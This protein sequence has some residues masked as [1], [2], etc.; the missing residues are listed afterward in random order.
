MIGIHLCKL[1]FQRSDHSQET[2]LKSS[3]RSSESMG[4]DGLTRVAVSPYR[5]REETH[6]PPS[7]KV[8]SFWS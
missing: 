4:I 6:K 5:R 1:N 2:A 8:K 3:N 7:R